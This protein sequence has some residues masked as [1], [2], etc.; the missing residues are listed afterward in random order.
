MWSWKNVTLPDIFHCQQAA[1]G[2]SQGSALYWKMHRD[3]SEKVGIFVVKSIWH[4][5]LA[6]WETAIIK[7]LS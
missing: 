2:S 1:F 5:R 4:L 6:F 3:G 7:D